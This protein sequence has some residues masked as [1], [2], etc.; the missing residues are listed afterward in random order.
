MNRDT[1]L[2]EELE[3]ELKTALS[4]LVFA[5]QCHRWTTRLLRRRE[6]QVRS[7][8]ARLEHERSLPLPTTTSLNESFTEI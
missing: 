2:I 7:I 1:Q 3:G 5:E 8:E 6:E 4:L